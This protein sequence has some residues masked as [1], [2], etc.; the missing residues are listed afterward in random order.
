MGQVE[1]DALDLGIPALDR[2]QHRAAAGTD[3]H[4]LAEAGEVQALDQRFGHGAGQRVHGT[5]EDD[6]FIGVLAPVAPDV[7]FVTSIVDTVWTIGAALVI[8]HLG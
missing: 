2:D 6:S 5:V 4:D 7:T 1:E 3:V 8:G